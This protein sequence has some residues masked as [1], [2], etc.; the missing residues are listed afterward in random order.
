[1]KTYG[2]EG[3]IA[4]LNIGLD[5]IRKKNQITIGQAIAWVP[6]PVW[7]LWWRKCICPTMGTESQFFGQSVRSLVTVVTQF[8]PNKSLGNIHSSQKACKCVHVLLGRIYDCCALWCEANVC[9]EESGCWATLFLRSYA[10]TPN[11]SGNLQSEHSSSAC[12]TYF[13]VKDRIKHLK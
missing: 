11:E 13:V 1:M 5:L 4:P 9:C 8:V 3:G 6:Q 2:G 7:T 12:R 10:N